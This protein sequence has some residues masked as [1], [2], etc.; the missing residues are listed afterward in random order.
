MIPYLLQ[1]LSGML[2]TNGL[3]HFLHGVSGDPFPSPF[4]R[5]IGVAL[6]PPPVN[7]AWGFANLLGGALL[8]VYFT[9]V[10][11]AG[12]VVFCAGSLLFGLRLSRRF[13]RRHAR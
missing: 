6:S 5:P 11:Y 1:L 10:S 3:P 13:A 9:P 7:V 4:T 8:L 2:L 12:W